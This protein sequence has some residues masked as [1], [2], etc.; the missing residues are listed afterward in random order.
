MMMSYDGEHDDNMIVMMT[1]TLMGTKMTIVVMMT[2][3]GMMMM[4]MGMMLKWLV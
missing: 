4:M 3:M 2:M 1:V